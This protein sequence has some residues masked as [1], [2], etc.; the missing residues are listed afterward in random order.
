MIAFFY[1]IAAATLVL[2]V[3]GAIGDAL[4]VLTGYIHP[5]DFK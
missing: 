3:F 5:W 4:A 2:G 1:Y